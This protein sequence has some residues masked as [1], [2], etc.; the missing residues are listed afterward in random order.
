MYKSV[1][2]FAQSKKNI[3]QSFWVLPLC[4][5]QKINLVGV[6]QILRC[7]EFNESKVFSNKNKKKKFY[8]VN[9]E[10]MARG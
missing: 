7:A 5:K 1:D 2:F 6:L 3:F 10:K 9:C 8:M 4:T